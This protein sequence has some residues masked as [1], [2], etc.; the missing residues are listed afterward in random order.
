MAGENITMTEYTYPHLQ[1][2]AETYACDGYAIVRQVIDA[3]LVAEANCHID[4]LRARHPELPPEQLGYWLVPEDPFWLRLVSDARLVDVAEAVLGPDIAL[5]AADYIAKPP[6]QGKKIAWHQDASYW[7]L[8]PMNVITLWVAYTVSHPGNGCVRVIP[9]TQHM[10]LQARDP[11]GAEEG[12]MLG[13]MDQGLA[14]EEMAVDLVLEPGDVSVHHPLILHGSNAN[15][16]DIWRRG[17]TYQY[18]PTATRVTRE[19][20]PVFLLR[21]QDKAGTN[22]YRALPCYVEGQHM[23][24]RGCEAWA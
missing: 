23:P 17:G 11:G 16:S 4:W 13:G 8:E 15:T 19:N 10:D 3:Q 5:F 24:F 12:T 2:L 18:I 14:R 21:G 6:G 9:G 1:G 7:G 20:W 22:R